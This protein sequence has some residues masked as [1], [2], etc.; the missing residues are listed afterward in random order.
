MLADGIV[1]SNHFED[2]VQNIN[3][4]ESSNLSVDYNNF[5]QNKVN[6]RLIWISHTSN[7]VELTA[8]NNNFKKTDDWIFNIPGKTAKT[9]IVATNNYWDTTS[10]ADIQLKIFDVSDRPYESDPG[11]VIFEPFFYTPVDSA[12]IL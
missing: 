8:E 7:V 5:F 4:G 3:I 2:S 6:I 1:K 12:G 10:I 9:N 11:L